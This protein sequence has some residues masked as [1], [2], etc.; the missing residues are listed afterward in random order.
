MLAGLH[1]GVERRGDVCGPFPARARTIF[2][3]CEVG[4]AIGPY[5]GVVALLDIKGHLACAVRRNIGD[6]CLLPHRHRHLLRRVGG[7]CR[8]R[9]LL[10]LV[11]EEEGERATAG[12]DVRLIRDGQRHQVDARQVGGGEHKRCETLVQ[13]DHWGLGHDGTEDA[14]I[15]VVRQRDAR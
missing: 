14:H 12:P 6:R 13:G 9:S 2:P 5:A 7:R 1:L 3:V 8:G 4:A 15:L 11:G 10:R